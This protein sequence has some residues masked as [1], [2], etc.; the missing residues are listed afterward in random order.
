MGVPNNIHILAIIK[1]IIMEAIVLYTVLIGF[2][3]SLLKKYFPRLAMIIFTIA[4]F[5]FIAIGLLFI[6]ILGGGSPRREF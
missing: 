4:K 1:N 3:Y 5:C 2:F 6:F